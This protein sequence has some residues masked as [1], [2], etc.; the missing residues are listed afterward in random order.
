MRT[1]V[2]LLVLSFLLVSP[3]VFSSDAYGLRRRTGDVHVSRGSIQRDETPEPDISEPEP[4]RDAF[5]AHLAGGRTTRGMVEHRELH[6]TFDDGPRLDT[7]PI[8]LDHLDALGISATFFVVTRG[9]DGSGRVDLA[10]AA[11]AQDIVRRGHT[12]GGHTHTH[13]DLTTL[14]LV[15]LREEL[16]AAEATFESVLGGRPTLFRAPFGARNRQV[17]RELL[18]RGYTH[19]LWNIT[20]G[21]TTSRRPS[22]IVEAFER[23]LDIREH[24]SRGKGGIV[25][26]HD[27]NTRVVEAFPAMIEVLQRRNCELLEAGEELWDVLGSPDAFV[28]P[29]GGAAAT[30]LDEATREVR[31]A[32]LR[33]RAA[34]RC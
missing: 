4:T 34:E 10:K 28:A 23:S 9:F 21:D 3:F 13:R 19:M 11:I 22:D 1:L 27:T 17:N 16:D 7:T 29:R 12:L 5:A 24:H 8:L 14:S 20:S 2:S 33:V 25:L 31:Q 30:G 18:R 32:A 15:D 6:F 26:L